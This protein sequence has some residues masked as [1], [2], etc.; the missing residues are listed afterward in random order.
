MEFFR[1]EEMGAGQV[2]IRVRIILE[3]SCM[4]QYKTFHTDQDGYYQKKIE[5]KNIGKDLEK[6]EPS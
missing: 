4:K 6:L 5:N 3:V 1:K 2:I